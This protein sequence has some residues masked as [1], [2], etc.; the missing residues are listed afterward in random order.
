MI[1]KNLKSLSCGVIAFGDG[2]TD[3]VVNEKVKSWKNNIE[4]ISFILIL[5]GS[6]TAEVHGI[7][8]A[9]STVETEI[10]A[11][12]RFVSSAKSFVN[13]VVNS[14]TNSSSKFE[15]NSDS[16]TSGV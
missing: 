13:S 14:S 10:K 12:S 16:S 1:A 4:E 7:S 11:A 9:G 2:I 6:Q 3:S 15:I 5:A 8:S